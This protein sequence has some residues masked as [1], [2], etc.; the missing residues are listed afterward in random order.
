MAVRSAKAFLTSA[1]PRQGPGRVRRPPARGGHRGRGA[2]PGRFGRSFRGAAAAARRGAGPGVRARTRHARARPQ[3]ARPPRRGGASASLSAAPQRNV[4]YVASTNKSHSSEPRLYPPLPPPQD[5]REAGSAGCP[6]AR[7]LMRPSLRDQT[8]RGTKEKPVGQLYKSSCL[9]PRER[10][11]AFDAAFDA[12]GVP[13]GA[14]G[15]ARRSAAHYSRAAGR[16]RGQ[17]CGACGV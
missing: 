16:C 2:T 3:G 5:S 11:T 9:S 7:A 4:T 12:R 8:P 13:S 1:A 15:A 17:R 14:A 10:C 6:R